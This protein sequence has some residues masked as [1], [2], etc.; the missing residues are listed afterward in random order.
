MKSFILNVHH[1]SMSSH[2]PREPDLPPPIPT[3]L[4]TW[5]TNHPFVQ[6]KHLVLYLGIL[7]V[8]VLGLSFLNVESLCLSPPHHLCP[9]VL[10]LWYEVSQVVLKNP[11]AN[12]GDAGLIPGSGRSPGGHGNSFQ[13]SCLENS[14]DRGAW[15]VAVHRVAKR[16]NWSDLAR[17]HSTYQSISH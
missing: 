3:L 12:A 17:T 9:F 2:V 15:Q 8:G 5:H 16:H 4:I 10:A 1:K 6:S 11:P 7:L 14:M 13:Y